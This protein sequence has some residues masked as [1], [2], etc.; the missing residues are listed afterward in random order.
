MVMKISGGV[1][2]K[3]YSERPAYDLA[4]NQIAN[5]RA[6]KRRA[7][8]AQLEKTFKSLGFSIGLAY[9]YIRNESND[10]FYDYANNAFAAQL[11]LGH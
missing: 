6:D 10:F 11:S 2:E 1:Q 9:D 5:T 3:N 8:S 4:G 7:F